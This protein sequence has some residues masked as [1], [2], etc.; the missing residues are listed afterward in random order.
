MYFFLANCNS[1]P[2]DPQL[3]AAT[4]GRFEHTA[5]EHLYDQS[6][7][8]LSLAMRPTRRHNRVGG[9]AVATVDTARLHPRPPGHPP[10]AEREGRSTTC[11]TRL[12]ERKKIP[13]FQKDSLASPRSIANLSPSIRAASEVEIE[14]IISRVECGVS[15]LAHYL[16]WCL[17]SEASENPGDCIAQRRSGK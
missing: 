1:T 3:E 11:P 12:Y 8:V 6:A 14:L 4:R 7:V 10:S 15:S 5:I 2:S 16:G 9:R 17:T 13:T